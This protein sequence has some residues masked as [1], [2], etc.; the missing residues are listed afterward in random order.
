MAHQ[1]EPG[2]LG[3]AMRIRFTK[4]K[5]G[6]REHVLS[7]LRDD[8]STC[9]GWL[10]HPRRFLALASPYGEDPEADEQTSQHKGRPPASYWLGTSTFP[11]APLRTVHARF[12]AHRSPAD[13]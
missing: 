5:Q 7:C 6:E 13:G 3:A 8:G 10:A 4:G 1:H 9:V 12:R 11:S 2:V